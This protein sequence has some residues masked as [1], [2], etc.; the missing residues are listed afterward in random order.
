MSA[1]EI[2]GGY[3]V[4]AREGTATVTLRV[5]A[6][7]DQDDCLA[8]AAAEVEH[9]GSTSGARWADE[10]ERDAVLVDVVLG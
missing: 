2:V 6:D 1:A 8:A 10:D 7:P 4:V 9:L 5:P 3:A